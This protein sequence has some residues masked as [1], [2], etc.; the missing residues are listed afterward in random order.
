MNERYDSSINSVSLHHAYDWRSMPSVRGILLDLCQML[1]NGIELLL[2]QMPIMQHSAQVKNMPHSRE[3]ILTWMNQVWL[4][5]SHFF[6]FIELS[7][8][9]VEVE[10]LIWFFV[11]LFVP[12]I[13]ATNVSKPWL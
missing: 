5:F 2:N 4:L 7:L 11:S 8:Q 13:Y 3:L 6:S 9:L 1:A 10:K 12:N